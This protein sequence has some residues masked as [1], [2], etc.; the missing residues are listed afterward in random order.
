MCY[1]QTTRGRIPRDD[2]RVRQ[3]VSCFLKSSDVH[4]AAFRQYL[5]DTLFIICSKY[6]FC[7]GI[8][9]FS[10]LIS[11][12]GGVSLSTLFIAKKSEKGKSSHLTI[13][14][15]LLTENNNN[16]QQQQKTEVL[17]HVINVNSSFAGTFL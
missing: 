2:A 1:I 17:A 5:R 7:P 3:C 8:L 13:V 9:V 14:L 16:K 10:F 6:R 15:D 11:G 12:F 4:R